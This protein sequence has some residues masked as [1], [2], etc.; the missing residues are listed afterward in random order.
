MD[1]LSEIKI[2]RGLG[3]KY[4]ELGMLIQKEKPT[5]IFF[6]YPDTLEMVDK[7]GNMHTYSFTEILDG[8]T[9]L[10]KKLKGE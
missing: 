6:D 1:K 3:D 4:N 5:K 8:L 7:Q 10:A 9:M 2:T